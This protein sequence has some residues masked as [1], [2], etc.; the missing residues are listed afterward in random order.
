MTTKKALSIIESILF[1][2]GDPVPL[3]RLCRALDMDRNTVELLVKELT[4]AYTE[5][6]GGLRIIRLENSIQMVTDTDNAEFVRAALEIRKKPTLSATALEVLA[7]IAYKQ[8]VTRQTVEQIRGVD[9]S[10]TIGMLSEKGLIYEA[11]RLDV[12]GRPILY[13]T[14]DDFLRCFGLTS[15]QDLPAMPEIPADAEQMTLDDGAAAEK[16]EDSTVLQDAE[17]DSAEE[18]EKSEQ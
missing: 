14:T 2:A 9:S 5:N 16:E 18:T 13:R 6:A 4:D 17:P 10:Y 15:L 11:D 3:D 8:P 12:P 7:I 1:A